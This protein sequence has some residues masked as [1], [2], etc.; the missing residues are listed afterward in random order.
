MSN[1]GIHSSGK[2]E[3]FKSKMTVVE[4]DDIVYKDYDKEYN[5]YIMLN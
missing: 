5:Y 3:S 4:E 2:M 1:I